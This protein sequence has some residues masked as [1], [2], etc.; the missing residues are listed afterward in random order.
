M[1]PVSAGCL[2]DFD[3]L[4]ALPVK[5]SPWPLSLMVEELDVDRW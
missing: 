2:R 5:G 3:R 4:L 1:A